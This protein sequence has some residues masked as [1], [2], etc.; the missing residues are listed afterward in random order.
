MTEREL[1]VYT[2]LHELTKNLSNEFRDVG[3]SKRFNDVV[4]LGFE[5]EMRVINPLKRGFEVREDKLDGISYKLN[6][7]IDTLEKYQY[8][9]LDNKEL[10]KDEFKN[11]LIN[12]DDTAMNNIREEV[13][14][15]NQEQELNNQTK[16]EEIKNSSIR[17]NK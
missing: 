13:K 2:R 9:Y 1:K 14:K 7:V 5:L 12:S 6:Q 16:N 4:L 8:E 3:N 15:Y 10:T 17:K 11:Y